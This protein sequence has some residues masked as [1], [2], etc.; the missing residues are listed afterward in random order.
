MSDTRIPTIA[1]V[2]APYMD[3]TDNHQLS[4]DPVSGQ[5]FYKNWGWTSGESSQWTDFR[6]E[7]DKIFQLYSDKKHSNS[8]NKGE[9]KILIANVR[10]YDN[11]PLTGHRL[12]DKIA[13]MGT[14]NDCS[15][16]R[17]KRS[18]ALAI[19]ASKTTGETGSLI[20]VITIRKNDEGE[21]YLS[22]RNPE[23]PKSSGLPDGIKFC[24]VYRFIGAAAP[25]SIKQY[26]FI[27]NAKRGL[28]ISN[29][30][31]LGLDPAIKLWAW[32][33]ARY[34]SNKGVLGNPSAAIKAGVLLQ[35]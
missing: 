25:T 26:E 24:K 16:F 5:A 18:T 9:M 32:Y 35:D 28:I 20:P 10:K 7:S 21:H 31:E 13:L 29:F 27:G 11:D 22:V 6:T 17:V 3:N 12:L 1:E 2:F 30:A 34:E 4:I 19:T 8:E 15:L 33:I 14:M 23:K